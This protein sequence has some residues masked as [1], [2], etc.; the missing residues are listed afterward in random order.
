V[1][2]Q[3]RLNIQ[4]K[5]VMFTIMRNEHGCYIVDKLPN[6]TIMNSKYFVTNILTPFEQAFFLRGKALHQKQIV[7]HVDHCS[8]GTSRASS[9]WLDEYHMLL[10]LYPS[11]FFD[12]APGDFYLFPMVK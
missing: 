6:N 10:M 5:K 9:Q 11:Y 1:I 3:A 2:A 7:V 8:G 4:S 12:L